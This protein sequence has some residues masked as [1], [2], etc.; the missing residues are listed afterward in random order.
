[1]ALTVT[2]NTPATATQYNA[3]IP[4]YIR[5]ASDQTLNTTTMTNHNAWA[6]ISVGAGETWEFTFNGIVGDSTTASDIK[7]DLDVTGTVTTDRRHIISM[8][9][10]AS[11]SNDMSN[12]NLQ[13]RLTASDVSH[14]VTNNSDVFA[15]MQEKV[16]VEGGISGGTLT[17]RWACVAA[18][19]NVTMKAGG[20]MIAHRVS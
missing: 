17:Y 11:V 14:G 18:S 5:Q 3:L 1:M 6:A 16:I 20:H 10:T 8:G 4:K 19:G 13:A 15:T 9:V 12:V 7:T 2:A